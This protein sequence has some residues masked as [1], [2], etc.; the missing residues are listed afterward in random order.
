MRDYVRGLLGPVGRPVGKIP[1][2]AKC[3]AF[4]KK[5]NG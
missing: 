5:M 4:Y 1:V 3:A 2:C